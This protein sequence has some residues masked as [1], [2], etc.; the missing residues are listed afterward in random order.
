[1]YFIKKDGK[2]RKK[3]LLNFEFTQSISTTVWKLYLL[4]LN[5]NIKKHV[6]MKKLILSA[7]SIL[8]LGSIV[9]M[10]CKSKNDSDAIAPTYKDEASGGTGANPNITNVTTTGSIVISPTQQSSILSGIGTIGVWSNINCSTPA[11]LC[12]TTT[13]VSLGSSITICFSIAPTTGTYQFVN[14]ASLL[15]PGKAF[16]TITNPPNQDLG[17]VWYSEAGSLTVSTTSGIKATFSNIACK[18]TSSSFYAVTASGEVGC[19]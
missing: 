3:L 9:F 4:S 2:R 15:G 12:L 16:M 14:S 5:L 13:N 6:I 1:L 18:K 10:S 17:S 7:F 11:P 19:L 8:I